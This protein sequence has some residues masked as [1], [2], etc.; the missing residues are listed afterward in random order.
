MHE[1]QELLGMDESGKE[2]TSVQGI[3]ILLHSG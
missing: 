3:F 1:M 2:T